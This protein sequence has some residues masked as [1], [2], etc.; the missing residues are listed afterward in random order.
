[1]E[2]ETAAFG[3]RRERCFATAGLWDLWL[4][5]TCAVLSTGE[6]RSLVA[7]LVAGAFVP[8]P[9]QLAKSGVPLRYIKNALA[10]RA[11]QVL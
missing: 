8:D 10:Y 9:P 2:P 11:K 4:S 3:Y 7:E 6:R 5:A 1:M